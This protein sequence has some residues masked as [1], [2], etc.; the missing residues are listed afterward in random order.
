MVGRESKVVVGIGEVLWDRFSDGRREVGGAA[1]NIAYHANRFGDQGVLASRIGGDADGA[2]LWEKIGCL[3]IDCAYVQRDGEMPTGAVDVTLTEGIPTYRIHEN[4]A[5]DFIELNDEWKHL[6][7]RTDAVGF[8]T[9][10]QRTERAADALYGFLDACPDRCLRFL[11]VNLRKGFWSKDIL[12]RSLRE[13]TAVKLND[14]ELPLA[15]RALGLGYGRDAL[16]R[17]VDTYGLKLGILTKGAHGCVLFSHTGEKIEKP[18]RWVDAVDTV[19]AGDAFV[20]VAIHHILRGS[21]FERMAEAGNEYAAFITT[22]HSGS[23]P[24]DEGLL[25]RVLAR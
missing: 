19:G 17:L 22:R 3:G 6:A 20:S 25:N 14:E 13:A 15:A 16:E 18:G 24:I 11:D 1:L 10:C 23:P 12:D 2:D 5:Y 8:G 9:L 21:S 7:M 4:V